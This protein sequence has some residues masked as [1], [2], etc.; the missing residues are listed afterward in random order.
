MESSGPVVTCV[1]CGK[2]F[3]TKRPHL[4]RTCGDSEC[5][6]KLTQINR[7]QKGKGKVYTKICEICGL[8]YKTSRLSRRTCGAPG[9]RRTLAGLPPLAMLKKRRKKAVGYPCVVCG[10]NY[11]STN[12]KR[13]TCGNPDCRKE[14]H[15]L[16]EATK[17]D[18][19][20]KGIDRPSVYNLKKKTTTIRVC[21]RCDRKFH[22][23]G[24]SN[25]LCP[26]CAK[27]QDE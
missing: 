24:I 16:R 17:R 12:P 3:H 22:S 13:K 2:E 11:H 7:L 14:H 23:K 26:R 21:L 1:G 18:M 20:R 5:Q 10:K 8:E 6:K 9:C 25:R 15:R 19:I 4:R 27:Q